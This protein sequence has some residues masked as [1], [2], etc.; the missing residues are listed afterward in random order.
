MLAEIFAFSTRFQKPSD[1]KAHSMLMISWCMFIY[2]IIVNY[3]FVCT[4]HE[5][6][7]KYIGLISHVDL[8]QR[9]KKTFGKGEPYPNELYYQRSQ[10][11]TV[12]CFTMLSPPHRDEPRCAAVSKTQLW[13]R[14]RFKRFKVWH[15]LFFIIFHPATRACFTYCFYPLRHISPYLLFCFPQLT[16]PFHF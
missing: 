1:I 16:L 7:H 14:I 2:V 11:V 9:P 4:A 6:F 10:L 3:Q 12:Q 15:E 13:R 5:M 8:G